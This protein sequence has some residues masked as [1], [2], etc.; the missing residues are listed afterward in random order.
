MFFRVKPL[1]IINI[2]AIIIMMVMFGAVITAD[3]SDGE[4]FSKDKKIVVLDPGT[5]RT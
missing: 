4:P 1:L 3:R 5:W 2:R